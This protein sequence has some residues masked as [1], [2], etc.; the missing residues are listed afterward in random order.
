MEIKENVNNKL[1]IQIEWR[2][3][4]LSALIPSHTCPISVPYPSHTSP[5]PVPYPSHTCPI[6]VP[7]P[8]HTRPIPV[9]YPSHTCPMPISYQSLNPLA[10]LG[11]LK[12]R[13][14]TLYLISATTHHPPENFLVAYIAPIRVPNTS[15]PP[16][17]IRPLPPPLTCPLPIPCPSH[18][19]PL[20]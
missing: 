6:P 3:I 14:Q 11:L 15:L 12:G 5:I 4:W 18:T 9:P 8:S 19:S 20:P 13:G 17:L 16:T 7:Y 1:M 2:W 10:S